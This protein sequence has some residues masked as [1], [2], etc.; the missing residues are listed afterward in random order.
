LL[1][2]QSLL[3]LL[4]LLVVLLLLLPAVDVA[5]LLLVRMRS[6]QWAGVQ[7]TPKGGAVPP[8]QKQICPAA[9][10]GQLGRHQLAHTASCGAGGSCVYVGVCGRAV[11]VGVGLAWVRAYKCGCM[12]TRALLCMQPRS[13]PT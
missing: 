1:L 7:Q 5:A 9:V 10:S 4:L 2:L 3:L 6:A 11:G 12:H 8:V 13:T